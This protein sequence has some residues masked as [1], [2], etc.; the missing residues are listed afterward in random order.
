MGA[1][2][3]LNFRSRFNRLNFPLILQ[4]QMP[5]TSGDRPSSYKRTA[6]AMLSKCEPAL[7][8]RVPYRAIFE[9]P[10]TTC[11][12][13]GLPETSVACSRGKATV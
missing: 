13:S 8:Y 3:V 2:L 5:W 7:H 9:H 11:M 4:T 6:E 1:S 12:V 10:D